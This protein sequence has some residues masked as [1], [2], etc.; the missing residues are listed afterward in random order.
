[1]FSQKDLTMTQNAAPHFTF[2]LSTRD[3]KMAYATI[4][5]FRAMHPHLLEQ[6]E[7]LLI[8][9]SEQV[10]KDGI[11]QPNRYAVELEKQLKSVPGVRYVRQ[12]GP[13]SSC[14]YK[15]QVFQQARGKYVLCCDSH[16]FFE[17][18]AIDALLKYFA[19]NPDSADLVMGP[20]ISITGK[21]TATQQQLYV[22][23]PFQVPQGA[24]THQGIVCRGNQ[25]G[26]WAIDPRGLDPRQPAFEIQQQGTF[27]FACRKDAWPSFHPRFYG[28]GGNETYLMEKFRARGNRVL[29]LPAFRAIHSFYEPEGKPYT[30]LLSDR[31]R[32][33][34]IGFQELGREDLMAATKEFFGRTNPGIVR[35]AEK[36]LDP[37]VSPM[38]TAAP[39]P[40]SKRPAPRP[41]PLVQE[42]EQ[43]LEQLGADRTQALPF[44][45][46]Q[47]L[48]V[49]R[50]GTRVLEYGA[51]LSTLLLNARG[52][53]A[54]T[55]AQPSPVLDAIRPRVR[56]HSRL[57]LSR[58]VPREQAD[59]SGPPPIWYDWEPEYGE[60][61]EIILIHG[62]PA[63][64]PEGSGRVGALGR[65]EHLLAP[66]GTVFLVDS[67]H[68][69]DQSLAEELANR[70]GLKAFSF[71]FGG[72]KFCMLRPPPEPLG[73]GPG[74]ELKKLFSAR[75]F[76]ACQQ[77][78]KLARQMNQWG[79][80]GCRERFE[81]IVTDILPRAR[82]WLNDKKPAKYAQALFGPVTAKVGDAVLRKLIASQVLVALNAVERSELQEHALKTTPN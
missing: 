65:V 9:N 13:P 8:D 14:L 27:A 7:I 33:Y 43:L 38:P 29:C 11:E 49:V 15:E 12:P 56:E 46:F 60:L 10:I 19:E 42:Y 55:I 72:R 34:L 22:H 3:D 45:M 79:V 17:L 6:T 2:G 68:D 63:D 51:G 23:E 20:L 78:D 71:A 59:E 40:P 77:C 74:T 61:F 24:V 57:I 82:N 26:I 62:L 44:P 69:N 32:N 54:T 21:V 67:H 70:L 52:V 18:G 4:A 75:K 48:S 39:A 66:G 81:E 53:H 5:A 58:M 76:P 64:A 47:Q 28:F 25:L 35:Q 37:D 36:Q 31:I 80:D 50:P 73:E 30:P 41:N 16:V 1:M